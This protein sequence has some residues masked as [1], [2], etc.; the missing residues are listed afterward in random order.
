MAEAR[1][2]RARGPEPSIKSRREALGLSRADLA[3]KAGVAEQAVAA[4]ETAQKHAKPAVVAKLDMA[5]RSFG[6]A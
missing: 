2:T 3:K 6:D 1:I 5:L 4:V